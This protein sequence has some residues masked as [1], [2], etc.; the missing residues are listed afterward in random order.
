MLFKDVLEARSSE[1][2]RS[3][4]EEQFR[5]TRVSSN[6]KPCSQAVCNSFPERKKAL[7]PAFSH[8]ADINIARAKGCIVDFE[9]DQFGDP[10]PAGEGQVKHGAIANAITGAGIGSIK[11]R[12]HLSLREM[13]H[14]MDV[15]FLKGNGQHSTKL[16][17]SRWDT[18]FEEVHE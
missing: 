2:L 8:H 14:Q 10:K 4:I 16:F 11:N 3:R 13:R 6:G 7:F 18:V 9:S 12:L 17:Q 5:G 1:G 15:G